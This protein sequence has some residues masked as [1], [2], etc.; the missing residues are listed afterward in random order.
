M[1][2]RATTPMGTFAPARNGPARSPIHALARR[3]GTP[4]FLLSRAALLREARRFRALLP[5]V[6]PYYAVKANAHPEV[7]RTFAR[8]GLGFD[9][10]SAAEI[11]AVLSLGVQPSRLLFANTVKRPDMLRRAKVRGVDFMT[12]DS[13]WELDK[14]AR[15]CPGAR[16]LVRIKVP[17]VG[18]VVELSRKFGTDPADAIPLLVKALRMGLSPCG[19]SFHVGSQCTEVRNY[20]EAF[21]MAS[22]IFQDAKLKQLPLSIVDIGGGFPIPQRREDGDPF[23]RMAPVMRREMDRLFDSGIRIIAEPG[24]ALVGPAGTLAVR[25]IGRSIRENKNWYYLDDGVYGTLSG[26]LFDHCKYEFRSDRR[27]PT[28]LSTLAGPTCDALDLV[29][30]GE[31]LPELDVGDFLVVPNI[32]AY[33]LAS[34]T[35]FNGMPRAK[36]VAV[37]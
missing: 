3:H 18:S 25:V 13:E 6:Q 10:A 37:P 19:I 23:G 33:S 1:R 34:A 7:L 30:V 5:R 22:I 15:I 11:D 29:S 28:R 27:G 31:E 35:D 21:E 2:A 9:V 12:F 26:I 36:V 4:L 17:N 14:I 32:G 24:R 16:V 8:E 20:E